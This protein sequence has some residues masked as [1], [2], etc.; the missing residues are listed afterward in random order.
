MRSTEGVAVRPAA[1]IAPC[2][3]GVTDVTYVE[4]ISPVYCK[5]STELVGEFNIFSSFDS[6]LGTTGNPPNPQLANSIIT[7]KLPDGRTFEIDPTL[8]L[9]A[10]GLDSTAVK[11]DQTD[12]EWYSR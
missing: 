12:G 2:S 8:E 5:G 10:G 4:N 6:S 3:Q 9:T 7:V 11:K 1:T